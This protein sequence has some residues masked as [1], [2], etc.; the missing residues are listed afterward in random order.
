MNCC[1]NFVGLV[2]QNNV[3]SVTTGIFELSK[4][5]NVIVENEFYF[6]MLIEKFIESCG[7]DE[8]IYLSKTLSIKFTLSN[9]ISDYQDELR[10]W[11]KEIFTTSF[12]LE[13]IKNL[14]QYCVE[15]PVKLAEVVQEKPAEIEKVVENKKV[16]KV[17]VVEEVSST[18]E[19]DN[20]SIR[21]DS[22]TNDHF[23]DDDEVSY[24]SDEQR[25]YDEKEFK[26]VKLQAKIEQIKPELTQ[27]VDSIKENTTIK[28]KIII[29]PFKLK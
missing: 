8:L 9:N 14:S 16:E 11:L 1:K 21:S 2:K 24:D 5:F 13:C 22:E 4:R 7:L 18:P 26:A 3:Y 6:H 15:K 23:D 10:D 19:S 17:E 28:K 20:Y 27:F 25:E 29:N 12:I